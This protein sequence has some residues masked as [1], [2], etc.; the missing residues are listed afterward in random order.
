MKVLTKEQF[1]HETKNAGIISDN[2]KLHVNSQLI[3]VDE[4]T[5]DED[6]GH[7]YVFVSALDGMSAYE[8]FCE[9]T[10]VHESYKHLQFDNLSD[11]MNEASKI[12]QQCY[13]TSLDDFCDFIEAEY[14]ELETA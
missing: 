14:Q 7:Y 9:K 1:F 3:E 6:T 5:T 11:A 2:I 12:A 8:I 13:R 10:Q 4:Y